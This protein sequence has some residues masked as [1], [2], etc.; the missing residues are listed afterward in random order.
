MGPWPPPNAAGM[1]CW[2]VLACAVGAGIRVET[3][4]RGR[5]SKRGMGCVNGRTPNNGLAGNPV[6]MPGIELVE[7][8][9]ALPT[10]ASTN[11]F[12]PCFK[13]SAPAPAESPH[14]RRSRRVMRRCKRA[15]AIS[16]RF[17]GVISAFLN[18]A[19]E[20]FFGRNGMHS[21]PFGC[22]ITVEETRQAYSTEA[23]ETSGRQTCASLDSA[24]VA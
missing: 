22:Y 7:I 14:F 24:H 18:R 21:P 17:L 4:F 1:G 9:C 20:T 5:I 10:N 3:A 15:L 16:R 23:T 6:G 13:A 2:V 11:G 19:L 8:A 12:K